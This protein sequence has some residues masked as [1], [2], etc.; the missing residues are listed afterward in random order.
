LQVVRIERSRRFK[1]LPRKGHK[2][3]AFPKE[4]FEKLIHDR[5]TETLYRKPLATFETGTRPE[6]VKIIPVM[7]E[8]KQ[9]LVQINRALG[10][11]FDEWEI[12]Y[13]YR[14]FTDQLKRNPTDV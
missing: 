5:M 13:Y 11:G 7:E 8:G 1:L 14:L 9:A 2:Q 6:P 12:D 3:A 4:E 10:L